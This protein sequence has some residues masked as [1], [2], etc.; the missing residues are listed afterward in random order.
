MNGV[1]SAAY[2]FAFNG[3]G[4]A[5]TGGTPDNPDLPFV[6]PG[7]GGD[8]TYTFSSPTS[9]DW[10]DPPGVT[11]FDYSLSSGDF[12]SFTL[13]GS[14]F[15]PSLVDLY[16]GG[17]LT[18]AGLA[19]GATFTFGAGVTAFSLTGIN[20]SLAGGPGLGAAYPIQLFFT[21]APGTL[22]I[23]PTPPIPLSPVPEPGSLALLVTAFMM[24]LF[25]RRRMRP[26]KLVA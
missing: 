16:I 18:A 23:T 2:F 17:V 25:L 1:N 10:F 8:T 9:G 11:G 13:P 5:P 20:P 7:P 26:A 15:N 4:G 22:S 12:T 6:G 3:V 14:S 21:G 24:L 19:P